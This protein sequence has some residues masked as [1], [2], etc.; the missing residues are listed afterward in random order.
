MDRNGDGLVSPEEFLG[1]PELFR[2]LDLNSDG[3][4]SVDEAESARRCRRYSIVHD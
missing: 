3:F 4:I 1:P 2:R